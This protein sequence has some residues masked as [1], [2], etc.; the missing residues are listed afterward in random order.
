V[1]DC[2]IEDCEVAVSDGESSDA[3]V[4]WASVLAREAKAVQVARRRG[5]GARELIP[6]AATSPKVL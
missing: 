4:P 6:S 2:P 3:M 1:G 5:S